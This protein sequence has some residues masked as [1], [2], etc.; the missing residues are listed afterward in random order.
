MR[1]SQSGSALRGS[2]ITIAVIVILLG[3]SVMMLPES[4]DDDLSKIGHGSNIVVLVQNKGAS[5]SMDLLNLL[6]SVRNDYRGKIDFMIADIDTEEGKAFEQQQQLNSSVLVLFGPDGTR[7]NV[8]N[9]GV[10][11]TALRTAIN[12]AFRLTP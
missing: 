12:N 4:Y 7:L 5:Q 6:N 3:I 2:L 1:Y 8:I 11:E 10:D 9:S